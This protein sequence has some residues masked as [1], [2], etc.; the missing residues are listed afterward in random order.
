MS[1]NNYDW[2]RFW[3]AR[4][5]RLNLSDD[6]YLWDPDS[7]FGSI[8]NPDV[9]SFDA[10][11]Q[12]PCLVL[13]GEPGMGKTTAIQSHKAKIDDDLNAKGDSSLW[14]DLRAY[15]TDVRLVQ[16]IF[17]APVFQAWLSG[18]HELHLFLDSLDECLLR[19]DTV[20]NLLADEFNKYPITRLKLRIA[21]RTAEWPN[22]L[23][24]G[25]KQIWGQ[26]EV[27]VFELA[28]LRR[29]DVVT[30]A[31]SS[32]LDADAF[33]SEIDKKDVVP[34]AIKPITLR[35]LVNTYLR[36]GQFPSR[37]AD[38][39]REGC[40]ILCEESSESRREA[41][42]RVD[43]M[44]A[45][46]RLS[47]AARIAALT[48]FSNRYAIWTSIDTGDVPLEDVKLLDLCGPPDE[49]NVTENQ[50]REV[51]ATGLFSSRGRHRMG[52]AHQTYA[53]FLAALYLVQRNMTTTQIMSFL[54]HPD[55][56][57]GKIVPQLHETAAWVA[58]M[59]PEVFREITKADP[60]LLLRSDVA[61]ADTSDREVLV[62]TLLKAFEDEKM[63]DRRWDMHRQY[64]KLMHPKLYQQ[65][66]PY[67]RDRGKGIIVRRAAIDIAE[68]C[69][70]RTLQNVLADMALD[71]DE[72]MPIRVHAA[73]SVAQIG[74]ETTKLKLKP[75]AFRTVSDDPDD[76][77][78]GCALRAL[79]PNGIGAKELF[80]ILTPPRSNLHG[81]YR[82]FISRDLRK[83]LEP[84]HLPVALSWVA[85]KGP[86]HEMDFSVRL[87]IDAIMLAGWKHLESPQVLEAYAQASLSRLKQY[88]ELVEKQANKSL[89]DQLRADNPKRHKLLGAMVHHQ[90]IT[91]Q[92]VTEGAYPIWRLATSQD[93][94]WMIGMLRTSGNET[95][96]R[97]WCRLVSLSLDQRDAGQVDAV[98]VGCDEEPTLAAEFQWLVTPIVLGSPAA[99]KMKAD[100][101][102]WQKRESRN[103]ERP[104]LKPPPTE[105]VAKL[106]ERYEVG[107]LAA[108]W[109][110]NR[111]LTLEPASTHY[112][113]ELESDLTVLPG[114][115]ETGAETKW[116]LVEA[117][118][119]YLL[120]QDPETNRWLGNNTFYRPAFAGYRALR[121]V[122]HEDT[123]FILNLPVEVWQKWA[124]VI[125][126]YP[127]PSGTDEEQPHLAL[128][129]LAYRFAPNEIIQTL[130]RLIDKENEGG[131]HVFI[132]R[133]IRT[134]W[135][136]QI[137]EALFNKVKDKQLS[138][139]NTKVL[140]EQLL[141]HDNQD[142]AIFAK[143]LLT[144]PV[145]AVDPDRSRAMLA[146]CALL[147][148]TKDASWSVVWPAMMT[149]IEF[150]NEI[151][152]EVAHSDGWGNR[153]GIGDRLGEDE[154]S[155]LYIWLAQIYPHSED[156]QRDHAGFVSKRE[157]IPYWR[158]AILETLKTRGTVR[159]CEAIRRIQKSLPALSWLRWT[160]L[161]A[162]AIARRGTWKPLDPADFLKL[163]RHSE[164]RLVQN[165]NQLLDV[166]IESLMHLERKLQGETPAS[167][168]LWDK[169][170][171]TF[172]PK[173]EG[174]L[175]DFVKLHLEDDL[176]QRGVVVNREVQIHR[177]ERTDIHVTAITPGHAKD[178]Y[179]SITIII[180]AKGCWHPELDT[181]MEA[182]LCSQ[183]LV[184]NACQHGLYLVGWFNCN[185]WD[186]EDYRRA[187]AQKVKLEELRK[188]L[189]SQAAN[190]STNG[191]V[192]K[193][194]VIN[195]ALSN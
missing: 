71:V 22:G 52:W 123:D 142:A 68:A 189:D 183:Y 57:D 96:K 20:A 111:E 4:E 46:Q 180:E 110:L 132:T 34:L 90:S 121:L 153:A 32:G 141:D 6:G 131:G 184:N 2:K 187:R 60:D 176:K 146:A 44:S 91:E 107:D 162:E 145:P 85:A 63:H 14:I 95:E 122:L 129:S 78:K 133:K 160:L 128:V 117:A 11:S 51:L 10:V 109:Q 174:L 150:A 77:L 23:E 185:L 8:H 28:P 76:E 64:R 9:V 130:V 194:Y 175:C 105:R 127:T 171:K 37:Q 114:W 104:L 186:E 136:D 92:D 70:L 157:S 39:Y 30:A 125:L 15:Q 33:L 102:E 173:D 47:L 16:A 81:A 116:R 159:A 82:T 106:L 181:A 188:Q 98:L 5:G 120:K 134:C 87:L 13:L 27:K 170:G 163:T 42:R 103:R 38:L 31:K 139:Q 178:S 156:P 165:G 179:D 182:Q 45:E 124:P 55:D 50:I 172:R 164:T 97:I 3:C 154:L 43:T 17:Q 166:V 112:G 80:S 135:D 158:D 148:H 99:E 100:F 86:R 19:I 155:H 29:I 21:C 149:D 40:R 101:L 143:S 108:W 140:L 49:S 83:N 69:E 59:L 137:A 41:G 18:P 167:P 115:K 138:P 53:E 147:T 35:F 169:I 25:L 54:V 84:S 79:W 192:I 48:I 144:V 61:T 67:I 161:D 24:S 56:P 119:S 1:S 151:V 88:E 190:L 58:G 191:R 94:L 75:L 168:F 66:E 177:G 36:A 26:D 7:E 113:E 118:K 74:D 193:S 73:Y 72:P 152:A 62:T 89:D 93:V 12:S 65:L 126:S 195:A